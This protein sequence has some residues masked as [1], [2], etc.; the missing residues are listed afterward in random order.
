MDRRPTSV[1]GAVR[2]SEPFGKAWAEAGARVSLRRKMRAFELRKVRPPRTPAGSFRVAA[3]A[4]APVLE[5]WTVAFGDDIDEE[6]TG[7]WA[8][9]TVSRLTAEGDLWL[10]E[11]DG[12]PV[13]MA[14]VNRRTPWSSNV[15]LVYTP[16][17]E[18]GRGY[19]SAVVAGLSQR[20]LDAGKEWCALF[21]D[22]ANPTSN[23]IYSEI[24]YEPR[25]DFHHF[26]LDW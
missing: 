19:A 8:Q 14:A 16:P 17:Q 4:D 9:A 10:W 6:I 18:R 5:A 23:H 25:C 21:T 13:S 3:P 1:N 11:R 7:E 22:L 26:A 2:W 24:G 15:A 12:E 20:E